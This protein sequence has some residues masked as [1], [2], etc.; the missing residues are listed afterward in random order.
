MEKHLFTPFVTLI[1]V[2]E[3]IAGANDFQQSSFQIW[4]IC[5]GMVTLVSWA[6]A[7]LS[8]VIVPIVL[9]LSGLITGIVL[10]TTV[11]GVGKNYAMIVVILNSSI[12]AIV[13]AFGLFVC[14]ICSLL[15]QNEK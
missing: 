4:M 9:Y 13:L 11:E 14:F 3:I 5:F 15:F 8:Q 1:I 7:M 6:M 12:V 2:L 10:L